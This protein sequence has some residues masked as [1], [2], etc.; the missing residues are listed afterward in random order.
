MAWVTSE[1]LLG[2]FVSCDWKTFREILYIVI[3]ICHWNVRPYSKRFYLGFLNSEIIF[4]KIGYTIANREEGQHFWLQTG[5]RLSCCC[6]PISRRF[7][8]CTD[9][10]QWSWSQFSC[11]AQRFN[12]PGR[13]CP[14]PKLR[15]LKF[16]VLAQFTFSGPFYVYPNFL[17]ETYRRYPPDC[18]S[19]DSLLTAHQKIPS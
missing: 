1:K 2:I 4:S 14:P 17:F 11:R 10:Q 8:G 16:Y 15:D 3:T 12:L 9:E 13:A 19:W 18:P 7:R 5:S 6:L